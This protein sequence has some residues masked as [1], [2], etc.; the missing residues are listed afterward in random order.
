MSNELSGLYVD[1]DLKPLTLEE[2]G[3]LFEDFP[4]RLIAKTPIGNI[5]IST[6]WL[7]VWANG[8]MQP[9]ETGIFEGENLIEEYRHNTIEEAKDFHLM[10][11]MA[12]M[13][14]GFL[15]HL[16]EEGICHQSRVPIVAQT[17]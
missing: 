3:T 8:M 10:Q 17:L 12:Y 13:N 6:V 16:E 11:V 4:Y 2:W 15:K 1:K 7:G 9:F 5:R 14:K